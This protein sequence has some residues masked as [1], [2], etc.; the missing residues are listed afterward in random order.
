M[1]SFAVGVLYD[2]VRALFEREGTQSGFY[3][4]WREPAKQRTESRLVIFSPGDSGG[5]LGSILPPRKPGDNAPTKPRS[6]ADVDE[7]VTIYCDAYDPA[8]AESERAQYDAARLLFDDV[9]RAVYLTSVGRF[10]IKSVRWLADVNVRRK[11]ATI[12]L[13]I[14]VRG[15][16]PDAPSLALSVTTDPPITATAEV[17]ELD[18]SATI[19][20]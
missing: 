1:D 17:S 16:I 19:N 18:A 13:V 5:Q 10:S 6:L 7:L 20:F 11:G 3:F 14:G 15:Y 9:M 4:G 12:A 2:E 8:Q